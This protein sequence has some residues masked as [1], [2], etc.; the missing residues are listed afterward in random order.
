ME[1]FNQAKSVLLKIVNDNIPFA[2]V[3]KNQFKKGTP[4]EAQLKHTV[5]LLIGCEL[6]HHLILDNLIERYFE[7]VEFEKTIFLRFLIVNKLFLKRFDNKQLYNEAIKELDKKVVDELLDFIDS[8]NELIPTNLDKSSPEYLSLRFNTPAWIIKMW[9]KQYGKGLVFKV[10]KANYRH[11]I[12]SLRYNEKEI[13]IEDFLK[14]H[15][16][17]EKTP[18]EYTL[19]FTGKGSP[20]NIEEVRNNKMFFL[21]LISKHIADS[22]DIDPLRGIA[23]FTAVPNNSYLDLVVKYGKDV[24][25]DIITNHGQYY[26]DAKRTIE[27]YNYSNISIYNE[28]ANNIEAC[29]SKKVHTFIVLA[30]S[31]AFD[32]LR[33]TPDYFLK[34]KKENL[35]SILE[36]E[37][38][39]LEE[40]SKMVEEGGTLVYMVPTLNR[41]ESTTLVGNF[42]FKHPEFEMVEDKQCYPFESLDCC[43]YYAV[44]KNNGNAK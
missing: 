43:L 29:I 27:K 25:M 15:P 39:T 18:I 41:K 9:Q 22:L 34:V 2:L 38:L 44:L 23:M 33:S 19:L 24:Q 40:S 12:P 31:T 16:D 32:L 14:K 3:L 1:E 30:R 20:K 5:S 6:R 37:A 28:E 17:F 8:T 26:Y 11:S 10:L 35:D 42:L 4:E 21:K 13:D 7:E 36:E